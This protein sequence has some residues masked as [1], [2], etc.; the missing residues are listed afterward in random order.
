MKQDP[1]TTGAGVNDMTTS[2]QREEHYAVVGQLLREHNRALVKFLQGRLRSEHEAREV[3]QEAYVRLLQLDRPGTAGFLRA[4]LFRIAADLTAESLD[5]RESRSHIVSAGILEGLTPGAA[6]LAIDE[7]TEQEFMQVRLA[8]DE[9]PAEFRQ[10]FVL[11]MVEGCSIAETARWMQLRPL[12]AR[13]YV[14]QALC[15]VAKNLRSIA[16]WSG[17]LDE[18]RSVRD[19]EV[20]MAVHMLVASDWLQHLDDVGLT[21]EQ[22][23]EWLDWYND[24]E[25]NRFVFD[26]MQ[27]V[28]LSCKNMR[29]EH[30]RA[31]LDSLDQQATASRGWWPW[32]LSA[33][34]VLIAAALCAWWWLLEYR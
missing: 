34:L 13:Q 26:E 19:T 21:D 15:H 5:E 11:H 12:T 33:G 1:N 29:P 17:R 30:R 2:A 16:A 6:S 27:A 7:L 28:Y 18:A 23:V 22:V 10:A 4:Q 3:A 9:A 14:S 8:L 20:T 25:E 24:S 32:A 31:L